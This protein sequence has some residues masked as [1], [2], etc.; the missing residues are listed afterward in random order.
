MNIIVPDSSDTYSAS[1]VLSPFQQ[2]DGQRG[3]FVDRGVGS[4]RL[5]KSVSASSFSVDLKVDAQTKVWH[6][7]VSI[8]NGIIFNLRS[9]D[10]V[11]LFLV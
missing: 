5:A 8:S 7:I 9:F 1:E 10:V 6:E 4:P 3:L 11:S 2:K